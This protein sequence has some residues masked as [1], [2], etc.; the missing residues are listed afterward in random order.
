MNIFQFLT[1]LTYWLLIA[2]WAY[3]LFFLMQRLRLRRFERSLINTLIIILVIDA[4]RTL[5]ESIYFGAWYTSLS[6]FLPIGVHN[7][8][9]RPEMVVIPKFLNV[10]TATL[11]IGILLHRWFPAENRDRELQESTIKEHTNQLEKRNEQ[12]RY[13]I[14]ERKRA[15]KELKQSEKTHRTLLSNLNSGV[16]VH[17]ADTSIIFANSK[18]S[19]L[20][21]LSE[22]QMKGKKAI[23]PQWK[24]I[25]DDNGDMPLDEYP[26]NRVLSTSEPLRNMVVGVNRPQSGDVVW[27]LV[28][29]YSVLNASEQVEE[30]IINFVDITERVRAEK[31]LKKHREHLEEMVTERTA[32]VEKLNSGMIAMLEDLN[33]TKQEVEKAAQRLQET[34]AELETF[35]YS[36]SH[37]LKAPLRGIDGYS[38]LLLDDYAEKLDE[39]GRFFLHTIRN[40]TQQMKQLIDDLLAYSRLQRRTL[41]IGMVSPRELV[42][43]LLAERAAEI[44]ADGIITHVDI[45]CDSVA[46][47]AEGLAQVLRNLLDNAIK[48]SREVP[49]P[50]IEIGGRTEDEHCILWVRDNGQGFDMKYNERI[51]EIFQRLHNSEDYPGTGIGLAIVRTAMKR[52]NGRVWA[53]SEPG[54]GAVFYLEIPKRRI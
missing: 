50:H 5:F 46:A 10:I 24:F 29:G 48:F 35:T 49:D 19:K 32:E 8:L 39:E 16:V 51:F 41:S 1:P 34:N 28:N 42:D 25:N 14:T 38:R 26:V 12:L 17:A 47:E 44:E 22:D 27:V 40:A 23:D 11:I 36:V 30:V 54:E 37:D 20:L 6:G 15:E 2:M 18:A 9:V 31:E 7:F 13:E 4:L 45:P 33:T 43:A 53:E 3:I 21:G 52:M